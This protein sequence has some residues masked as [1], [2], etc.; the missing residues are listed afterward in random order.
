MN[1]VRAHEHDTAWDQA[2][3]GGWDRRSYLRGEVERPQEEAQHAARH[4]GEH[5]QR[6]EAVPSAVVLHVLPDFD[7]HRVP[8]QPA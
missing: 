8:K 4:H 1:N 5:R 2:L 7:R 6:Q 3:E